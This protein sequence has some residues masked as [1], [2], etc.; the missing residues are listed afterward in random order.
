M[1]HRSAQHDFQ[2]CTNCGKPVLA[3]WRYCR[4]CGSPISAEAKSTF[5]FSD[6]VPAPI[7]E[8]KAAKR[9][10][11]VGWL[12]AAAIVYLFFTYL[13]GTLPPSGKA[14]P[15]EPTHSLKPVSAFNGQMLLYPSFERICP[16]SVSV[17][18][19]E[20]DYYIYLA[21]RKGPSHSSIWRK[22]TAASRVED[23]LAFY[24]KAGKTVEVDVPVG[25]YQLYYAYGP[26]WYGKEGRFG[27]DTVF[28]T[29]DEYLDFY[30]DDYTTYGHTLSLIP[31]T[32]GNFDSRNIKE[33]DFP[34]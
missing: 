30:T 15:E 27:R 26:T 21:Y 18:S 13:N 22:A 31:Q 29:S 28:C 3:G 11:Y 14:L 32:Y 16:L 5:L 20:D 1:D 23:D 25:V 24:V 34:G 8:K 9:A 17:P 12:I 19:G 10:P 2:Y 6:P 4:G 33:T 7:K